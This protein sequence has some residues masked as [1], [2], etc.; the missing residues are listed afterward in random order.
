MTKFLTIA[1]ILTLSVNFSV[2]QSRQLVD[3]LLLP[4][5]N[6]NNSKDLSKSIQAKQIIGYGEKV[7][8]ILSTYFT[9]TTQ[10]KIKSE[11]Q[12]T[13]LSKGE[14]AIILCDRIEIMPYASLTGVQNCLVEFCKNNPNWIE[15]YLYAIRRMDIK[16][17]KQKYTNWLTSKDRKNWIPNVKRKKKN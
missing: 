13:Y 6:I 17:F 16:I 1:A 5:Y 14:V 3:S 9:D 10:T 8:P 7:L 2:G 11:C 12:S 4:L 15:Y